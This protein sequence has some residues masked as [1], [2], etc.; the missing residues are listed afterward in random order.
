M[1]RKIFTGLIETGGEKACH[2]IC[3][4]WCAHVPMVVLVLCCG[5]QGAPG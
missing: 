1:L 5:A 2:S 4:Q 3:F